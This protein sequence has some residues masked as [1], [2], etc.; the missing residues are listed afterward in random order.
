MPQ[1]GLS[2][3]SVLG[4]WRSPSGERARATWAAAGFH[5]LLLLLVI[6]MQLLLQLM[7]LSTLGGLE[8]LAIGHRALHPEGRRLLSTLAEGG[9][10]VPRLS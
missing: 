8:V 1:R 7:D 2:P 9:P 4:G 3:R 6:G 10:A 5:L